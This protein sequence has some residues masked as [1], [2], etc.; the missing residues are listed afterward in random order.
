LTFLL[1]M[2]DESGT[3]GALS[4]TAPLH[5]VVDVAVSEKE[6]AYAKESLPLCVNTSY[7]PTVP[8]SGRSLH[9][10]ASQHSPCGASDVAAGACV[11][12]Y[13]AQVD[14][15]EDYP[16]LAKHRGHKCVSGVP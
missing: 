14:T 6:A 5:A 3:L 10:R 13:P 15:T 12:R 1:D 4:I 2:W 7:P 8:T 11:G 9:A 16:A